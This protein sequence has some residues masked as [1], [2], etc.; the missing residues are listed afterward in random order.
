MMFSPV[1]AEVLLHVTEDICPLAEV[2][3]RLERGGVAQPSETQS[4]AD[5]LVERGLVAIVAW[6]PGRAPVYRPTMLGEIELRKHRRRRGYLD[7]I[8]GAR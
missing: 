2:K 1:E 4:A 8:A 3:D 6:M 7:L 5:W